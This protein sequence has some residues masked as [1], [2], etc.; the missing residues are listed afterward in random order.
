MMKTIVNDSWTKSGS[1]PGISLADS[2]SLQGELATS[3]MQRL[4]GIEREFINI[5]TDGGQTKHT[6]FPLGLV[7]EVVQHINNEVAA[8]APRWLPALLDYPARNAAYRAAVDAAAVE[9]SGR[10]LSDGDLLDMHDRL[11]RLQ[12]EIIVFDQ[13]GLLAGEHL[14]RQVQSLLAAR[15]PNDAHAVL[16]ALKSFTAAT[17]HSSLQL[18]E[19][20]ILDLAA[21]VANEGEAADPLRFAPAARGRATVVAAARSELESLVREFGAIGAYLNSN[22]KTVA[23]YALLVATCIGEYQSSA[24]MRE[25]IERV[26]SATEVNRTQADARAAELH[27][28]GD[29]LTL[30]RLLRE[31]IATRNES[32]YE[33]GRASVVLR[34][35]RGEIARRLG[36]DSTAMRVMYD[37][38]LRAFLERRQ[39]VETI[40]LAA[41]LR[42]SGYART[43]LGGPR[44]FTPAEAEAIY[45]LLDDDAPSSME[46][47]R[48]T[49][50]RGICG[51]LGTA[52]G[53]ARVVHTMPAEDFKK[54]DIL[55][56]RSATVNFVPLMIRAAGVITEHGG[57]TCH[58]AA[59]ARELGIPAVVGYPG[60]TRRFNTG[61]VVRID[62]E[63]GVVFSVT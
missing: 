9:Q 30:L 47:G 43:R 14:A 31:I 1:W 15:L 13:F 45:F 61:Q 11:R 6:W 60:A 5:F 26:R 54:G 38:E 10:T 39:A 59:I 37:D 34:A 52:T 7:D 22:A 3:E 53:P 42:F 20:A 2:L 63:N 46:A 41:R 17:W 50:T 21:R 4:F 8:G 36:F 27:L 55:I 12:C 51:S 58:A 23:D 57:I 33:L 35:M 25:R 18:E 56:A 44:R 19:M 32:A 29:A 24:A 48:S 40:D 62:A 49:E 16:A 28:A